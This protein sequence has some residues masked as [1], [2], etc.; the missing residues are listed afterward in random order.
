MKKIFDEVYALFSHED[1]KSDK[2]LSGEYLLGYHCQRLELQKKVEVVA[3]DGEHFD[4]D[5]DEEKGE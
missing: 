3:D 1:F 4:N 2:I 5:E